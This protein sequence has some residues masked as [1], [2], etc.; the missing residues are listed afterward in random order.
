MDAKPVRG[1]FHNQINHP[2]Q[3]LHPFFA[4]MDTPLPT[5]Q[6]GRLRLYL[7]AGRTV[8][9]CPDFAWTKLQTKRNQSGIIGKIR[10]IN[11]SR[12]ET[13]E[14]RISARRQD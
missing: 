10:C 3:E 6:G 11:S 7:Q 8:C 5:D 14:D 1:Q 13:G 2:I 4:G 12:G 9:K